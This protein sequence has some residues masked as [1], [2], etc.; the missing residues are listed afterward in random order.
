MVKGGN[1]SHILVSRPR[2]NLPNKIKEKESKIMAKNYSIAEAVQ[3]IVENEDSAS[4]TELSKRFPLLSIRIARLAVLAGE[5]LTEFMGFF[6]EHISANKINKAIKEQDAEAEEDEDA[7][8]D[9]S[10]DEEVEEE[11]PK[12]KAG[13]GRPKKVKEEEPEEDEEADDSDYAS[14][15]NKELWDLLGQ[16]GGRK[17]CREEFGDTKTPDMIKFFKKYYPNG[18]DAEQPEEEEAAEESKYEG[19]SAVELYKLCKTRKLK[20]EQKKPVKYYIAELEKADAAE[21]KAKAAKAKAKKK[22]VEEEEAEWDD[23]EEEAPKKPAKKA[24]RPKKAAKEEEADDEDDDE[25]EI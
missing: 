18:V 21:E 9:D 6:P 12:K 14:M 17:K 24:G 10:E 11:A 4:I 22:E 8:D 16:V 7:D 13:R 1:A 25:W 23:D 19:K 3:I 20:V 5:E 15:S 2:A